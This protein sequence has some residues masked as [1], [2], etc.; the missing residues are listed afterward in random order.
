M[1]KQLGNEIWRFPR[2]EVTKGVHPGSVG[3][4]GRR[5]AADSDGVLWEERN[6]L[7]TGLPFQ[8][9]QAGY[10][11]QTPSERGTYSDGNGDSASRRSG[12][13][14]DVLQSLNGMLIKGLG[15]GLGCGDHLRLQ[16]V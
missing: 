16:N 8:G 4:G 1:W 15:C 7:L 9:R 3:R 11:T 2:P 14:M 6:C 13:R 5:W 12:R 10:T